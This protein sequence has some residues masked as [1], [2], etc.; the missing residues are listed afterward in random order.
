MSA[1]LP[2]RRKR[3]QHQRQRINPSGDD[4]DRVAIN[5]ILGQRRHL[6]IAGKADAVQQDGFAGIAG[7]DD[8]CAGDAE[9]IFHRPVD[10]ILLLPAACQ[11]A[12][13]K[14]PQRRRADDIA[15]NWRR[16]RNARAIAARR[17]CVGDSDEPREV[18]DFTFIELRV[19][20]ADVVPGAKLVVGDAVWIFEIAIELARFDAEHAAG[21]RRVTGQTILAPGI[22]PLLHPRAAGGLDDNVLG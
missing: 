9:R 11:S 16:D 17:L 10:N 21:R 18:R 14:T 8:F 13:R 5:D 1:V 15:S 20:K 4:G 6:Q 7:N 12:R 3:G 19:K 22:K 2:V